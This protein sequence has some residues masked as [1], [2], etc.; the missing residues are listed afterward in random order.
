MFETSNAQALYADQYLR[1]L[2]DEA[3]ALDNEIRQKTEQLRELKKTLAE[4]AIYRDG[5]KTGRLVSTNFEVTIQQ[6]DN[7][8]WDQT[9][10]NEARL[11]MGDAAF[12]KIMKWTFEPTSAKTLNGFLEFGDQGQAG[13]I[14]AARTVTPGAPAVT[15]ERLESC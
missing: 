14:A 3:A 13:L 12:F 11:A 4:A 8:K 1:G 5:S 6:R 2:I 7:V 9:K 10:L 15:F